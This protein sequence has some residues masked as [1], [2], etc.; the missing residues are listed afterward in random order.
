M[1]PTDIN[2]VLQLPKPT[3]HRLCQRLEA[4]RFLEKDLDGR[5]YLPGPRL[6]T[7]AASTIGFSIYTQARHAV[8]QRLSERIGETCNITIPGNN[9]MY[10]LDRVESRWPLR[11]HFPI[12]AA[13]P[14]HCTASGKLYL[15]SLRN[16]QRRQLVCSMNLNQYA[17]NTI[18]DQD[19]LLNAL[20]EIR[21]SKIG[22]DNEE[23]VDGMV[24]IAVPIE[25]ENDH[26]IATLAVH[27]P[28]QRMSMQ[29]AM[30]CSGQLQEAAA[31]IRE[32]FMEKN[33]ANGAANHQR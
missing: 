9:G 1:T 11:I 29:A 7:I 5:R 28:T 20:A 18:T 14:L 6:R 22:T 30:E 33:M 4:E 17:E 3:I 21:R 13:V 25:D 26:L 12:G 15:S 10:Y 24:A 23:L 32:T 2:E 16:S 8:L 19:Q 31:Q 27:A